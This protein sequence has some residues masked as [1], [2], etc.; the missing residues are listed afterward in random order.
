MNTPQVRFHRDK[1]QTQ[2]ILSGHWTIEHWDVMSK[3]L[4]DTQ[5]PGRGAFAIALDPQARIDSYGFQALASFCIPLNIKP[6]FKNIHPQ[7]EQLFQSLLA[8]APKPLPSFLQQKNVN[9]IITLFLKEIGMA[10]I[11]A[12]HAL[13]GIAEFLGEVISRAVLILKNPRRFRYK[14]FFHAME[15]TGLRAIPIAGLI[16]F[17]IGIVTI[18]QGAQQLE[19]FGAQIYTINLLGVSL[20]RELGILITA[21]LLAGRSGSAFTAQI[22][23]MKLNQE[24]DAMKVMGLNPIDMLVIPRIAAL[25]V[26]MPLLTLFTNMVAIIGGGFMSIELLDVSWKQFFLQLQSAVE[27]WTFWTGI[28]KAPF[29]GFVI[30]MVACEEGMRVSLGAEDVGRR[31]TRSVVRS[32]F[33]IIVIDAIFSVLYAELGV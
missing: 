2:A 29:F 31:T 21:I 5:N 27:P 26:V 25:T 32:I 6:T 13:Y 10:A 4:K 12:K 15:E 16:A 7:E 8:S 9:D 11:A 14:T 1:D 24:I 20:L 23:F 19:K 17:L 30:A 22:G 28:I 3:V 33:L 18:Y